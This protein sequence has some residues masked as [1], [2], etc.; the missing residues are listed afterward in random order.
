[1]SARAPSRMSTPWLITHS[2]RTSPAA[3]SAWIPVTRPTFTPASFTSSPPLRP[4][5]WVKVPSIS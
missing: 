1:M 3:R 4:D 2:T 5:A